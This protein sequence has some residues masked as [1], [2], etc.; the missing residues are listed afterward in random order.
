MARVG[1]RPPARNGKVCVSKDS[2]SAGGLHASFRERR[3]CAQ[4]AANYHESSDEEETP[5][6]RQGKAR[7]ASPPFRPA[8][9]SDSARSRGDHDS[10]DRDAGK[11]SKKR[12]EP[13]PS[14]DLAEL[15][16]TESLTRQLEDMH[17]AR[18][19]NKA[20]YECVAPSLCAY[21]SFF[22]MG[23]SICMLQLRVYAGSALLSLSCSQE[24]GQKVATKSFSQLAVSFVRPC[25]LQTY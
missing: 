6:A 22:C 2:A 5:R 1:G 3:T 19:V 25:T 12:R 17:N 8:R 15:V 9:D 11:G 23:S 24:I 7:Q 4:N 10:F 16:D 20:A 18:M 13:S 14:R 21:C